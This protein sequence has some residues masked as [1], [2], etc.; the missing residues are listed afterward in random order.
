MATILDST[1]TST[2]AVN[3]MADNVALTAKQSLYG[4]KDVAEFDWMELFYYFQLY[5][6]LYKE[7]VS[8]AVEYLTAQE[9]LDIKEEI[10]QAFLP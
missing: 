6:I 1:L 4:L 10:Y 2:A 8:T 7:N 3:A 5:N 9:E